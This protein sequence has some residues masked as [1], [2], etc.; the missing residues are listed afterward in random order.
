MSGDRL[1][2]YRRAEWFGAKK[3]LKRALGSRPFN[4]LARL[5]LRGPRW[6]SFPVNLP[7]VRG[8]EGGSSFVL[9]EPM[10]CSIARELYWGGGRR[11]KPSERFALELFCRLARQADLILDIG[12]NTGIFSLAAAAVN[13]K[14]RVEA[15]EIVPEV[16]ELLVR[17][18][19]RNAARV[20]CPEYGIGEDGRVIRLPEATGG[21]LPMSFSSE[22]DTE[23]GRAVPL[24]SLD[25]L[26]ASFGAPARALLKIDVEGTEDALFRH[27]ERFLARFSPDMVC[28]LLPGCAKPAVLEPI[29]EPLGYAFFLIEDSGLRRSDRLVPDERYHDW[30][31]TTRPGDAA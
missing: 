7:E 10:R 5:V 28:E 11:I 14:A 4:D 12:A 16:R 6:A 19:A 23:G 31:L 17:N 26:A 20:E 2:R 27:A 22:W 9:L 15:F 13:P 25:A 29:L 24:R 3:A 30:L 18:V 21:S 1:A 8:E